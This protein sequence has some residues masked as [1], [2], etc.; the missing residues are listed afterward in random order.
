MTDHRSL[1]EWA[2]ENLDTPSG[3]RGRKARWHETLSQFRIDVKYIP[4]KENVVADA[5]SRWAYPASSSREDVSFHGSA[6][7]KMEVKEMLIK[8][9]EEDL[10]ALMRGPRGLDH[11]GVPSLPQNDLSP[12]LI[13][14]EEAN[15]SSCSPAMHEGVGSKANALVDDGPCQGGHILVVT[16]SGKETSTPP[17]PKPLGTVDEAMGKPPASPK[18][19]SQE[20]PAPPTL[21]APVAPPPLDGQA[22]DTM[23]SSDQE[24]DHPCQGK[25]IEQSK[26][27]RAPLPPPPRAVDAENAAKTHVH[28]S[29]EL[30]GMPTAPRDPFLS[31]AKPPT[32][33]Q[34]EGENANQGT[35]EEPHTVTHPDLPGVDTQMANVSDPL[36]V[37]PVRSGST[38][39]CHHRRQ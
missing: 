21:Q 18:C 19:T 29:A 10:D 33:I 38:Y 23:A 17:E 39:K 20:G 7:A 13:N 4:G 8:E 36:M 2:H 11:E 12:R 22:S 28:P 9:Q 24:G 37:T 16:R 30:I 1:E 31:I 6:K 3:P 26:G 32:A 14:F 35:T 15:V 5:L 25:P 34:A 27:Y